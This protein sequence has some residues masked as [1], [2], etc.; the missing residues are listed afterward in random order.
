[1]NETISKGLGYLL[2]GDRALAWLSPVITMP[3]KSAIILPN[4]QV[5]KSPKVRYQCF[6][7]SQGERLDLRSQRYRF[8]DRPILRQIKGSAR[9][10][11]HSTLTELH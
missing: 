11:R 7:L 5:V 10:F 4:H 8:R 1:M 6:S 3:Q 2:E 9:H